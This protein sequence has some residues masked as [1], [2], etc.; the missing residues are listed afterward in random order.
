MEIE[1][2]KNE[3]IG[4]VNIE[5][6]EQYFGKRKDYFIPKLIALKNGKK[7][8]FNIGAFFFG[9]FWVFYRRLYI[10]SLIILFVVFVESKIENILL[11]RLGDTKDME[12]SIKFI[13]LITFG[14]ILGYFGNYFFLKRSINRVENII[15]STSDEKIKMEN[16]KKSGSGNWILVLSIVSIII[17]ALIIG[18][19]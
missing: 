2:K 6:F 14:I 5:Y 8:S 12:I 10:H 19:K 13:W 3:K 11:I 16:L 1:E 7:F 4:E 18:K 17:L 9:I 15:S